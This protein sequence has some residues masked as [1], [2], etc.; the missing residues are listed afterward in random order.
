MWSRNG[1]PV[2]ASPRPA[3]SSLSATLTEVS[4][5]LRST[6][7]LRFALAGASRATGRAVFAL[8]IELILCLS[9][10]SISA[11]CSKFD[12]PRMTLEPFHPRQMR[13]QG[14]QRRNRALR[15][16]DY[17]GSLQK[18]VCTQRRGETRGAPGRQD[19]VGTRK[20]VAKRCRR[21]RPE[22]YRTCRLH[23]CQP[24]RRIAHVELE[25]LRSDLIGQLKRLVQITNNHQRAAPD[26]CILDPARARQ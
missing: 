14:S 10:I 9:R 4:R 17:T 20:V 13:D 1:T 23:L 18:I 21:K 2:F 12:R 24:S 19:V 22:K 16:L 26:Q 8:F 25:M 6:C 7:A 15:R 5:V 3:P 11:C